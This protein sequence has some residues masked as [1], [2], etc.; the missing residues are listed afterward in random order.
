MSQQSDH[1]AA[2]ATVAAPG[3]DR[4]RLMLGGAALGAVWAAGCGE[5]ASPPEAG[6][7]GSSG[8]SAAVSSFELEEATLDQLRAGMESG[9]WSASR[10]TE[11]YLERIARLDREGPTLRSVIETNPDALEIAASLDAERREGRVRGPLHGIPVLLKDNIATADRT[12]TTAGSLALQGSI[13]ARDSHVARRLREAGAVLLGKANLS[14]WA[15]F[16]SNGSSSGWSARGGQCRNPYALDRNPCGSSSGSGAAVSASLAAAA[17]GTETNGSIV[18]PSSA[19]GVVGVK[20]TVGLVGRTRI[21]PIA[22]TQDTAGPLCRTVRDAALVLGALAGVD[23]EDPATSAS[24]S[25]A[26]ADYTQHLREDGLRGARIGV[27]RDFL[28]FD[29]RVDALVEEAIVAL[30]EGG[31]EVIDPVAIATRRAM[32]EPSF[33][34]LLYEFR[35]D[36]D[37]Y[38]A[39]LGP[40]APVR[41]LAE[42]IAFNEAHADR[43]MPYFGQDLLVAAQEKGPL[44]EPEYL[45]ARARALRLARDEGIDKTVREHRL[46]AMVAPTG[47]PAWL[48]DLVNGDHFSGGSSSPAAIAGY[49]NVTVPMGDV[50]GLP[51]GISFFGS[52]W[53]EAVLLRLAY[54]FEQATRHRRAPRF[55]PTLDLSSS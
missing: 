2:T 51:V 38:L 55:L 17:I 43:E 29:S 12:T 16:R 27:A 46:D 14:E 40:E 19:N 48:T 3:L 10:I 39:A 54:A 20:P 50:F 47:G 15:N 21:I 7:T 37:A 28:G 36:L 1:T 8:A 9:R 41:S 33:Q 35:A 49:P 11:L 34:V 53:S 5:G 45:E 44:S 25:H 4:R 26:L 6:A 31:A 30:R 24:A 42:V 13:P 23:P 22:H 52:A 32:G 18:C